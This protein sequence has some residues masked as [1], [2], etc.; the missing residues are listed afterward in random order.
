MMMDPKKYL[1]QIGK[2]FYNSNNSKIKKAVDSGKK[3]ADKI[4]KETE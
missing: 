2:E 3:L 1:T 4:L